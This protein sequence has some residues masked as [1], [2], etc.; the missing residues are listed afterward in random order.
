MLGILLPLQLGCGRKNPKP[1]AAG[2][3]Q[4]I[5]NKDENG[6]HQDGDSDDDGSFKVPDAFKD[7][8]TADGKGIDPT[9]VNQNVTIKID[10]KAQT[11]PALA[12]AAL[13][14]NK[15]LLD[16]MLDSSGV[17]IQQ[18]DAAANGLLHGLLGNSELNTADKAALIRRLCKTNKV[19]IGKLVAYKIG[20]NTITYNLTLLHR[21][22]YCCN[23][24][25][26]A[27]I[28]AKALLES[29]T[30]FPIMKKDSKGYTS[31]ERLA[32]KSYVQAASVVINNMSSAQ[33]ENA[34]KRLNSKRHKLKEYENLQTAINNK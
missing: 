21:L 8:L 23:T 24:D 18:A 30:G 4:T 33:A 29:S 3:K 2:S 25:N 16:A 32:K 27:Q 13:Q 15:K 10:G 17:K 31:Y 14:G 22:S 1:T 12:A 7:L 11:M 28:L 19:A 34:K 6:N 5:D 9:K 20:K 26:D